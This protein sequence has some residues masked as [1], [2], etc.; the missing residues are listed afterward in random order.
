MFGQERME[1][2]M[3]NFVSQIIMF[4]IVGGVVWGMS[5]LLRCKSLD[6]GIARP[7][8]SS[9]EALVAVTCSVLILSLLS[10]QLFARGPLESGPSFENPGI[11]IPSIVAFLLFLLPA[12]IFLIKAHEPLKSVGITKTNLWQSAVIGTGL[13]L[14]TFY[15]QHNGLLAVLNV[16]KPRHGISF[17]YFAFIG[18]EEE[19]LFRGYLQTRLIAWLGKWQGWLLASVI[20]ALGHFPLRMVIENKD[21]VSA[22]I[23]SCGLFPASI[24]FGFIMMKTNNV[25]VP[26]ILHTFTNWISELN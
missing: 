25:L 9:L 1:R 10:K 24:F 2:G 18:F 6:P 4:S 23:D 19:I 21:L 20:M 16:L 17:I 3:N 15:L 22:F 13:A 5:R 11:L 12:G 14:L 8:R 7:K 26:G